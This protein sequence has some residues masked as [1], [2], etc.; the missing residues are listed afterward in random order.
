MYLANFG[1]CPFRPLEASEPCSLRESSVSSAAEANSGLVVVGVLGR[2]TWIVFL[3]FETSRP[4]RLRRS[5]GS[6]VAEGF[7]RIGVFGRED[8]CIFF[9]QPVLSAILRNRGIQKRG[10]SADR[11]EEKM[12]ARMGWRTRAAV[13]KGCHRV[14][15]R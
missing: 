11:P 8:W 15:W 14:V 9:L 3:Q 2:L 7:V 1:L 5:F 12:F 4:W 10:R 6:S 13:S